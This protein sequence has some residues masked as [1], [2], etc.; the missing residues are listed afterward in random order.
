[1]LKKADLA[2][3]SAKAKG[4][5]TYQFYD[6]AMDEDADR[7]LVMES[8]L[9]RA[10]ERDEFCLHYQPKVAMN[11]G[12]VTALEA[13]VRWQH[14]EL[15][16]LP[17]GEFIPLAEETGLIVP[18]GEWVLRTACRQ[19]RRWQDQGLPPVRMAV[20]LSGYQL[21]QKGLR[22]TVARILEE[23]GLQPAYLE[24]EVTETV[25]MQNPDFAAQLLAELRL[26]GVHL[27]IDD[28]GTG[29]S[30]LAHL[31][32]FAV[33][34]LK[35]D[36]S[37]VRDVAEN[38]TDA[39]IASAI[40]AMG[41]SLNL[42]VIAEGVETESQFR[43]LQEKMCDEMQGYLFSRPLATDDIEELLA[44]NACARFPEGLRWTG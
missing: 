4:R 11:S 35:I 24:L 34:T 37:F 39:A 3:Y 10:L 26:L 21:Q 28:F 38:S 25:I 16:L 15:G 40:I 41:N 9:R 20:N 29:Y 30:S 5:N 22:Q 2:M 31:K 33:N 23:T 18:I 19:N 43:F 13:L 44:D 36:K 6:Q 8:G 17:P 7:R 42:T 32:R 14:P 27:S 12:K 1:M